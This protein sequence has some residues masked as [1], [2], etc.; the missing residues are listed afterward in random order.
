MVSV[1]CS[2]SVGLQ[3]RCTWTQQMPHSTS[4]WPVRANTS[5]VLAEAWYRGNPNASSVHRGARRRLRRP[6][7]R[8]G[9]RYGG[10]RSHDTGAGA[11]LVIDDTGVRSPSLAAMF[12][13]QYFIRLVASC[14]V[15]NAIMVITLRILL[16]PYKP[17]RKRDCSCSWSTLVWDTIFTGV[18]RT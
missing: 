11:P 17:R 10:H 8:S 4:P 6:R 5:C 12:R 2:G 14:E 9:S 1:P 15:R 13:H 7:S 16:V 3:R 18:Q